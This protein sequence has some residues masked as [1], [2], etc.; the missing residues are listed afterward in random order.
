MQAQR[1]E[2]EFRLQTQR[3]EEDLRVEVQ[4][5]QAQMRLD[6]LKDQGELE[7]MQAAEIAYG[8]NSGQRNVSSLNESQYPTQQSS[9]GPTHEQRPQSTLPPPLGGGSGNNQ[10]RSSGNSLQN[11]LNR[12]HS[13]DSE[14]NPGTS[15][16]GAPLG[17][18]AVPKNVRFAAPN[19][20]APRPGNGNTIVDDTLERIIRGDLQP[21]SNT[22]NA[23]I[24]TGIPTTTTTA[25]TTTSTIHSS[26]LT[27]LSK[28]VKL[29]ISRKSKPN[30]WVVK[31]FISQENSEQ[32][33]YGVK[34]SIS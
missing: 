29:F 8:E 10:G 13:T 2:E 24:A 33:V 16:I 26:P 25:G 1:K 17:S 15:P 20:Q 7:E 3:K 21:G 9:R 31:L 22:G 5:K 4:L 6:R 12:S 18:E 19:V 34:L 23:F 11:P 32:N 27:T 14:R 28:G 30:V